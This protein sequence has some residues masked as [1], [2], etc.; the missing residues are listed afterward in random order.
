MQGSYEI[1]LVDGVPCVELK[2]SVDAQQ[3]G[4]MIFEAARPLDAAP[5]K[6]ILIDI[7]LAGGPDY[8][9]NAV[10]YAD[11]PAFHERLK[12]VLFALVSH[13]G[14]ERLGFVETVAVNRGLAVRGFTDQDAALAWLREG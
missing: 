3:V 5:R 14:D 7:R 10:R 11:N 1:H 13:A 4:A 2:G 8:R 6:G 9:T 12:G